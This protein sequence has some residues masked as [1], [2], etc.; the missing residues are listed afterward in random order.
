MESDV[1]VSNEI[2][3]TLNLECK[4]I[5]HR[6]TQRR[7]MTVASLMTAELAPATLRRYTAISPAVSDEKGPKQVINEKKKCVL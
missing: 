4:R 2:K 6:L 3:L 5:L 7:K 1:Q